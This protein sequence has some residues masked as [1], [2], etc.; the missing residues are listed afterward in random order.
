MKEDTRV[1]RRKTVDY[2]Y[3]DKMGGIRIVSRNYG[4]TLSPHLQNH[5]L[6]VSNRLNISL[7]RSKSDRQ[8]LTY[9][10]YVKYSFRWWPRSVI[11]GDFGASSM[12]LPDKT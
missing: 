10:E 9:S 6:M 3:W 7:W 2:L 8:M 5:T 11:S 1:I 12:P 4:E